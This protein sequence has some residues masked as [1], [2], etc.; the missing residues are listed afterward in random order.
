VAKDRVGKINC[1]QDP[2]DHRCVEPELA[3]L[4]EAS[5]RCSALSHL[6]ALYYEETKL[7]YKAFSYLRSPFLVFVR[8]QHS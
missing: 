6:E 1:H 5:E 4:F 2:R 3:D 8:A 7:K